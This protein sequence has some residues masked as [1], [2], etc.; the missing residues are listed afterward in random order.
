MP[1]SPIHHILVAWD[2]S[3]DAHAAL[4]LALH[5]ARVNHGSVT[6]VSVLDPGTHAE[7]IGAQSRAVEAVSADLERALASHREEAE[8]MGARLNHVV[9]DATDRSDALLTYATHHAA[10]LLIA[11]RRGNSGRIHAHL[12]PVAEQLLSRGHLPVMVTSQPS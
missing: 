2:A 5:L 12:G 10:D 11:G 4:E 9:I 3:P 6:A 1:A 7:T 8:A